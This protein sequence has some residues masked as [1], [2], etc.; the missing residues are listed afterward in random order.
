MQNKNN[1]TNFCFVGRNPSL[2]LSPERGE[3]FSY[4]MRQS[5]KELKALPSQS[6]S[7]PKDGRRV[8]RGFYAMSDRNFVGG[9]RWGFNSMEKD[10]EVKGAG[11]ASQP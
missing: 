2:N 3:T 10:D 7:R 1:Y 4:G 11:A 5:N 8:G 6:L 9:Y